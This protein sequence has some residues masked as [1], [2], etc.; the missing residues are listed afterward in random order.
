[1]SSWGIFFPTLRNVTEDEPRQKVI[2][3]KGSTPGVTIGDYYCEKSCHHQQRGF[4]E[5]SRKRL[6]VVFHKARRTVYVHCP[7]GQ[8]I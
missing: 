7:Q 6:G 3:C 4:I 8:N 2:T 1:M 5:L